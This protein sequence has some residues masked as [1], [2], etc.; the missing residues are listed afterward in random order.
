MKNIFLLLA[1][2]SLCLMSC[3]R[4]VSNDY[5]T[6]SGYVTDFEGNP[7]DSVSVNWKDVAFDKDIAQ[8]LTDKN[9]YY[10]A[11]V[12]KGR[13]YSVIGLNMS[14]YPFP[15]S[16]LPEDEQRLEF[17]AWNYIADRDTTFNIRYHR[18]EA[19]GIHAF[20]I[21][22]ATPAYT[23]YVRPISLTRMQAWM[24]NKTPEILM[25]PSPE[26][27]VVT[28][29]INGE[30]VPI[31]MIQEVKEYFNE[32]EYANAYLL[33]VGLPE[34]ENN[35]PYDIFHVYLEDKENG[36]KGEGVYFLDKHQYEQ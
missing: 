20:R 12:K 5:V 35:L 26:N 33:S 11:Q 19:Y 17:W 16:T 15:G 23:I 14:K 2:Y 32:T 36:D 25:A 18:M 7:L 10:T 29:N 30:K 3:D 6:I 8:A 13:Y 34:K 28:I 24:K 22:G 9:G 21:P 31:N 4:K 1:I 27:A